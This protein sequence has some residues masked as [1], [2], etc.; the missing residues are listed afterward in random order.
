MLQALCPPAL[1]GAAARDSKRGGVAYPL[2]KNARR[3]RR[4]PLQKRARLH[5]LR[6][7]LVRPEE[8]KLLVGA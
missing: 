8:R 2:A 6:T 4:L 5:L 7:R 3:H 1:H